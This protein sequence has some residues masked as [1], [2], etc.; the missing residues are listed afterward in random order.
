MR[1]PKPPN[2]PERAAVETRIIQCLNARDFVG[3]ARAL[4]RYETAQPTSRGIGVD[5]SQQRPEEYAVDISRFYGRLPMILKG[6]NPE[7]DEPIRRAA[8]LVFLF[9]AGKPLRRWLPR[10]AET[11]TRFSG[12][13]AVRMFIFNVY[14]RRALDEWAKLEAAGHH[15]SVSIIPCG[16]VDSCASCRVISGRSFGLSDITELPFPM[17]EHPTGCRCVYR[18][19]VN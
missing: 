8:A 13:T 12:D 2:T 14:S 3:A 7:C 10:L 17:C 1:P 5:W 9:G 11:G 4:I 15:I 16:L 19:S 6:L 18:F